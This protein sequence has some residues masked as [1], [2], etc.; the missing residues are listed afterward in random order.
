MQDELK[1]CGPAALDLRL[2]FSELELLQEH[3]AFLC[4]SLG[5]QSK[6][7]FYCF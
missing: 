2:P 6:E 7:G 4:Q 3:A 5:L 1:A